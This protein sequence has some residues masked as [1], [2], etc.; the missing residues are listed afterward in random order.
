MTTQIPLWIIPAFPL[1]GA[2][3]LGA[4]A[5]ARVKSEQPAPEIYIGLLAVIFPL[6]SFVATVMFV[7]DMP[8][9]GV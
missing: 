3:L 2:I 4:V 5:L 9:N 8:H 7:L 6:L 1:L